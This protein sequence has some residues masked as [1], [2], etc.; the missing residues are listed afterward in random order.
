MLDFKR[1]VLDVRK[2][3]LQHVSRTLSGQIS[4]VH[5][6]AQLIARG[7][8]DSV[9][10][11]IVGVIVARRFAVLA[12]TSARV[13]LGRVS[14]FP[15]HVPNVRQQRDLAVG[16]HRCSCAAL[17]PILRNVLRR[18]RINGRCVKDLAQHGELAQVI[19]LCFGRFVGYHLALIA[20]ENGCHQASFSRCLAALQLSPFTLGFVQIIAKRDLDALAVDATVVIEALPGLAADQLLAHADHSGRQISVGALGSHKATLPQNRKIR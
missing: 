10:H 1:T 2:A 17:V 11:R 5:R 12:H 13:L 19:G 4:Q 7:L 20:A 18:D 8:I 9:P 15:S 6:V 14:P 16:T 3:H